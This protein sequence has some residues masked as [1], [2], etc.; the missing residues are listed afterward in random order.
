MTRLRHAAEKGELRPEADLDA[1]AK[2]LIGTLLFEVLTHT[3]TS[4]TRA[5][6]Y[7]GL[8]DAILQGASANTRKR[9]GG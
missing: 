3:A 7:D 1:I 8:L 4:A 5:T 6:R 9:G 2:A